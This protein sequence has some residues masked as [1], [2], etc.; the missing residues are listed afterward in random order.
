V[1]LVD[2]ERGLIS[3]RIFIEPEIYERELELV[4]LLYQKG[5]DPASFR[6]KTA[7]STIS[8]SKVDV[9]DFYR[10]PLQRGLPP[11][12]DVDNPPNRRGQIGADR[13]PTKTL[14]IGIESSGSSNREPGSRF[15]AGSQR[16]IQIAGRPQQRSARYARACQR[17][18]V[19]G[20]SR[21]G[22][23]LAASAVRHGDAARRG[24]MP[25]TITR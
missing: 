4:F 2:G 20:R 3:R 14:I 25:R 16:G 9:V 15:G 13:D 23:I 18:R 24:G 21:V 5:R 11:R 6:L 1:G 19:H 8:R 22:P 7:R 17:C 10:A 12:F